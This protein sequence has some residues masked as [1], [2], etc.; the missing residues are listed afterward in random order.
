MIGRKLFGGAIVGLDV[1]VGLVLRFSR[2]F[3]SETRDGGLDIVEYR[4]MH[5]TVV[6]VPI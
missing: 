3:V 4:E 2:Q 1:K 6:I 5:D